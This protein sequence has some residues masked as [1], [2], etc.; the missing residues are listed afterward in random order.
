[1]LEESCSGMR[2]MKMKGLLELR[3]KYSKDKVSKGERIAGCIPM[4]FET[5]VLIESLVICWAEVRSDGVLVITIPTNDYAAAAIIG[6]G[7]PVFAWKGETEEEY[8]WCQ[9]QV[10]KFKGGP[11]NLIIDDGGSLTSLLHDKYPK[12]L[13]NIKGIVE[14]NEISVNTLLK[15]INEGS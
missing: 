1:M 7:I 2:R 10:L 4:T 15:L 9:E 3:K 14:P 11:V 8:K 6:A 5:A 12:M 13:K